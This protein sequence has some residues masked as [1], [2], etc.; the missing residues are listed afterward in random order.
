MADSV[1][2]GQPA[3]PPSGYVQLYMKDSQ[4]Y[5]LD[6]Q[7]KETGPLTSGITNV[8]VYLDGLL[9][10]AVKKFDTEAGTVEFLSV[11]E[12]GSFRIERRQGKVR[13]EVG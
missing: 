4:I 7:G 3:S 6:E 1:Q 11:T 13:A 2:I 9:L 8:K 10:G 12:G 5:F